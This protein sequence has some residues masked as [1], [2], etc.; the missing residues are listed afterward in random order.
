M[1]ESV[2]PPARPKNRPLALVLQGGGALGAYQVGAYAALCERGLAPR[3]L[4]GTSIGAI[5]AA[6]IAGNG[7]ERAHER[8]D[9]FWTAISTPDPF[10][11]PASL[12]GARQV[13]NFWSAQQAA[14]VGQPGF[15]A[16]RAVPP[17]AGPPGGSSATSFYDMGPL[18]GTLERLV[19]FDRINAR[20]VRLS[21]GA[22]ELD[23]GRTVYFDNHERKIVTDHV[24]AS[25]ALPPAFAAVRIEGQLY[26]DGGIVSNTPLDA[27]LDTPPGRDWLIFVVDLW[28]PRGPE[29]KTLIEVEARLKN[30]AY[31]SRATQNI[32]AFNRINELR[33]LVARLY[34]EMPP[35]ADS[36]G[37]GRQVQALGCPHATDILHL[38]YEEAA[39]EL[40]SKDYEF[41]RSSVRRHREQGY[42]Q[43]R[44]LLEERGWCAPASR[45]DA[46]RV[47]ESEPLPK[48][49]VPPR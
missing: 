24:L 6:I 30:I 22:V 4:A 14:L 37:L 38:V 8:L 31:A 33:R 32:R 12:A 18:K 43:A 23:T 35:D 15:F 44:R 20:E 3:W 1:N 46:V 28:D 45:G 48:A 5:N 29:P 10:A 34:R 26:W 25:C 40:A 36:E 2:A 11:P 42:A 41:S 47:F 9:E 19:D 27:I 13:Y 21:L 7:P 16:P 39:F 17:F 49:K